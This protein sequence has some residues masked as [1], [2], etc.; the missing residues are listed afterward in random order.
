MDLDGE[1]RDVYLE[2][3][4]D[5]RRVERADIATGDLA[6]GFPA[7][8]AGRL[9]ID[10]DGLGFDAA[11]D[12]TFRPVLSPQAMLG[13]FVRHEDG[14]TYAM[15]ADAGYAFEELGSEKAVVRRTG[16]Y[17]D[18]ASGERFCQFVTRF[19][20]HRDSPVVRVF[21]T[22]IFT[23][24]GNRDRIADMG[25]RFDAA[26]PVSDGG[27]LSAF[28][29]G[30]W[31]SGESVV[32]FD[33]DRF[34]L[35]DTSEEQQGRTP[36]VLS[37]VVGDSRV[38]FGARDFWQNFPSEVEVAEGGF[39]FYNWPKR[40]PP[41]RFERPVERRDAFRHRFVHEGELLDFRIPDEYAEGEIWRESSSRE[42]HIAEGRP[43]SANAQGI[44]RTEEMFLYF[45]D[46]SASPDDAAKVMQGLNDQT[47]R[48][49]ADPA[50]VCASGAFGDIHHRDPEKYPEAERVFD[51]SM[52]APG[53]WVERLGFYGNSAGMR[54]YLPGCVAG[55]QGAK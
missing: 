53:R 43:E 47:L 54:P 26:Q 36:G 23:G 50:W 2:Y 35:S 15:P 1:P 33:F 16:W 41:A 51:L 14:S 27:I 45:A 39:A 24:D 6:A 10:E 19:V 29:G 9:R 22:W 18:E 55:R 5:V 44:A 4:T 52:T 49:V 20:F 21:H 34:L 30:E 48:A 7:L 28:E 31:L 25:W 11:G 13:A 46:A 37:A 40:N 8:D 12:G 42:G 38:T 32:Q 3:G 17:V